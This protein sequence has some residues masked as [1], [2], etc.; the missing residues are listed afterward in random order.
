MFRK[1]LPKFTQRNKDLN[2]QFAIQY[3]LHKL[4]EEAKSYVTV[5]GGS[6]GFNE[7]MKNIMVLAYSN[8]FQTIRPNAD[9]FHNSVKLRRI[10]QNIK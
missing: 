3:K 4:K 2:S 5:V 10:I 6:E 1:I 8:K 7:L 9:D